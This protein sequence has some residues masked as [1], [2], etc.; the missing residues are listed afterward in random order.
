VWVALVL[1]AALAFYLWTAD[2]A[3][4]F[5]FGSN[6]S[7]IYN[8]LT[9][10]FLHGH[11]YLPI[12]VP[13]GLL[14]L[15]DA[16]N[17]AQNAPYQGAYH[18]LALWGGHFYSTWGPS[19]VLL[20][21]LF[22]LTPVQMSQSFAVAFYAFVG[23]ACAVALLHLLVRRLIPETPN[24]LVVAATAG[25]ALTNTEPFMLRRPAQYEVA[26]SG[27]YCFEM[28]G[29]LLAVDAVL[30]AEARRVR[31]AAGSLLLGLA[32]AARPPLGASALVLAAVASYAIRKRGASPRI[33]VSA[34]VPFVV[35]GALLAAYNDAR[36]GSVAQFGEPYQLASIDTEHKSTGDLAYIPPGVF[37]YLLI[38]PRVAITFP[39][40]FLM[41]VAEYPGP[42]PPGYAGSDPTVPVEPA[43]GMFPTMP[44]TLLLL[45][46]P[47]LWLRS[48]RD[49]RPALLAATGLAIL[50]LL[51][52]VVLAWALWGTT[53]RYEVDFAT[54]CLIPSF[55]VW[56]ML[57]TSSPPHRM[58]RRLLAAAGCVLTML[59]AALG[60]AFSFTGYYETL[61][62]TN[63]GV[64]DTLE[65]LT[66]PLATFVTMIAGRPMIARVSS[67]TQPVVLPPEGYGVITEIGATTWLGTGVVT[68]TV[69]APRAQ[70]LG[71]SAIPV[72]VPGQPPLSQLAVKVVSPGQKPVDFP[73]ISRDV[74]LPIKVHWGL[75][76]IQ[77]SLAGRPVSAEELELADLTLIS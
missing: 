77:L 74:R 21:A 6:N 3:S 50:G 8:L 67:L 51:V 45:C 36:F 30:G 63:P 59:G 19:P 14:A 55:M 47:G 17:P 23:L 24:W 70:S 11:L 9:T 22:R 68:V 31:L 26:I 52:V 25:L 4:P 53:Q 76:R 5:A 46:L 28:A 27:G 49:R 16:Y 38:P 60:L 15:R 20:F 43:G 10:A 1:L 33:L 66:S 13:A 42:F 37:S 71:L 64:F 44:I 29:L 39:H 57:L 56:A 58:R 35:C 69:D 7:D 12:K 48:R 61:P 41:T 75:N 62:L 34:L 73:L 72:A 40:F 32:M 54:L 65:D 2:T 18:D